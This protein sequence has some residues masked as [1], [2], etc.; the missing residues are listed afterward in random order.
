VAYDEELLGA[1]VWHNIEFDAALIPLPQTALGTSGRT[2]GGA[3]RAIP[4]RISRRA[5]VICHTKRMLFVILAT[6]RAGSVAGYC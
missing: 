1:V 2:M 4:H 3:V 6:C 5:H